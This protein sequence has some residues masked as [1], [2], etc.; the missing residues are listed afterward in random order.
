MSKRLFPIL[1]LIA[2]SGFACLARTT[3]MEGGQRRTAPSGLATMTRLP[4]GR[5]LNIAHRG[6]RSLAPENTLAAL[7]KALEIGADG[8]EIDVQLTRDGRLVIMH[9]DTL[10]RTTNAAKLFP[11]RKPWFVSDFTLEEIRQLDAGSWFVRDDP[12]GQIKAGAVLPEACRALAGERVP[13]FEEALRFTRESGRLIDI[14]I[15]NLPRRYPGIVEKVI[16]AIEAEGLTDRAMISSFDH[17]QVSEIKAL[18]PAL[19]AGPIVGEGVARPAE[20]IRGLLNGDAYFVAGPILGTGS[21]AFAGGA[22]AKGSFDPADL[23]VENL[24]ALRQAGIPVFVW[25]INDQATM[26][27]LIAAGVTGIITDFP[28]RL[29]PLLDAPAGP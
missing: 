19:A 27:P 13:T 16:S 23:D 29:K 17:R 6:A 7:R 10:A 18:K 12:F 4:E 20:Y 3:L 11:D 14:E 25:T 5:I 26:R 21:I 2:A 15:K 28:Q 1:I 8:W 24:R 9:D 22:T